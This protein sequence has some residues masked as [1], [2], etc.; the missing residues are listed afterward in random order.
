MYYNICEEN[1]NPRD[2]CRWSSG[3][4][5]GVLPHSTLYKKIKAM[6]VLL[7]IRRSPARPR[8]RGGLT[9][10]VWMPG[11][12]GSTPVAQ[13]RFFRYETSVMSHQLSNLKARRV[14][15]IL[16]SWKVIIFLGGKK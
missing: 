5:V 1:N 12:A 14:F 15:F 7:F 13:A 10:T 8:W 16:K 6:L 3:W 11:I 2:M 4:A 9:H